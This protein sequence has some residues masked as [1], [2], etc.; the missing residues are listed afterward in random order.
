[1][2]SIPQYAIGI[3]PGQD[4]QPSTTSHRV[5]LTVQ[6][7]QLCAVRPWMD[8][9]TSYPAAYRGRPQKKLPVQ[10]TDISIV[11]R[12]KLPRQDNLSFSVSTRES[13][14]GK[15]SNPLQQK[16]SRQLPVYGTTPSS[17]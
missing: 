2:Y 6:D 9:S 1:M 8:S 10:G 3:S 12:G 11:Q 4:I 15:T 5:K 17:I 7:T 16:L 13:F 14:Q